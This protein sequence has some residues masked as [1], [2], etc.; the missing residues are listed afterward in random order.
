MDRD[1]FLAILAMDSYNRGYGQ[2]IGG[3]DAVPNVTQIGMATIAQQ[4]DTNSNTPGVN[5]GFY[6]IAYDVGGVAGFSPDEKVISYRGTDNIVGDPALL[7]SNN[8]IFSG[9]GTGAGAPAS[10]Q[11]EL[12]VE[13]YRNLAGQAIDPRTANITLTGHSL[14]GGLAG[15]VGSLYGKSGLLFNNMPFESA[16]QNA[17]ETTVGIQLP[18]P[19]QSLIQQDVYG[20]WTPWA[21]DRSNLSGIATHNYGDSALN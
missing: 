19:T 1:L 6:A 15:F 10:A 17:Y 5:A 11:A 20:S 18:W 3:L 7:F 4:S 14:G 12:A 9:W 8:D 2:G 16:A 13:F 21:P